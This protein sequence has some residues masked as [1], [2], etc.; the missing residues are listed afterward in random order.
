MLDGTWVLRPAKKNNFKCNAI[1]KPLK[2]A[3]FK[4]IA[5]DINLMNPFK[6]KVINLPGGE[7]L[8]SVPYP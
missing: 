1:P 8:L 7:P 2:I 5:Q 4:G 3:H 6:L